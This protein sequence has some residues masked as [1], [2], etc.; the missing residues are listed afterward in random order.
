MRGLSEAGKSQPRIFTDKT[1][2]MCNFLV[3]IPLLDLD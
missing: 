3:T 2:I 1:R